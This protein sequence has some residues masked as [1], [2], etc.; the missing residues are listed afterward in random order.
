M[1]RGLLRTA[2]FVLLCVALALAGSV[3]ALRAAAPASTAVTLGTVDVKVVPARSGEVDVYV[4]VVD[5]G[6]RA[7]PFSAP[8]AV[9]LE[10]RSLDRDAALAALRTGGSAD[11]S[12]AGLEGELHD[13]VAGG[14]RRAGALALLG[15]AVGG[16]LGGAVIAVFT[17]RR[18]LLLGPAA[19]LAVTFA[20]VV[21]T[22]VGVSRFDYAALREPTF[23]AHG[24]ELPRLLE[25]SERVLA[26]GEGYDDSYGEAVEGLTR[27]IAVAGERA[28]QPPH[29]D[30]AIVVASDLH[31]NSLV[32][33]ALEGFTSGKPVF[34]VGDLTQRGTGYEAGILPGIARLGSPVVA[35]SGNH[36][37]RPLM[38]AAARRGVVVLT[39]S[40][41]LRADGTTDGRAVV[42]VA[43]LRVAGWDDPAE[44][45]AGTLEGKLL[46]LKEQALLDARQQLLDWFAALP[47]RPDVVLVH[48]HSLAHD[49]LASLAA[50]GGKP[51]LVLTGH[52]HDQHV[53]TEGAHVLVDGGSVGA[54]GAFGVGEEHS[55]FALVHLDA[56]DRARAVDLVEV[57]PASGAA[58][59]HRVVLTPP[60]PAGADA[61]AG[62]R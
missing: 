20:A 7:E 62:G 36:D 55:G 30:R 15:G 28:A 33:P 54:G 50:E 61:E 45:A 2:A 9:G 58:S 4:P 32:L 26:A 18:W 44:S 41:R 27:L 37:S 60:D 21:L 8:L 11:A 47:E 16:L 25:F 39:R 42:S 10:F 59:A 38:L 6:V 19:G 12:L 43:G 46:E 48:R 14:L 56:D 35:V 24:Q 3:V 22:G 23:Y 53:E 13:A 31:S 40:G 52:D 17:R 1:H 5:W 57:E 34:L 49:L 29:I 51:V